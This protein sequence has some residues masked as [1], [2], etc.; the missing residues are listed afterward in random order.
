MQR[1]RRRIQHFSTKYHKELLNIRGVTYL[2]TYC[3]TIIPKV[4]LYHEVVFF[5]KVTFKSWFQVSILLELVVH[6]NNLQ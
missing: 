1:R 2:I 6:V 4:V 5:S 3:I